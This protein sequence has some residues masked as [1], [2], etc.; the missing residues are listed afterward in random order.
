MP[1][2]SHDGCARGVVAA[3]RRLSAAAA[4]G[5]GPAELAGILAAG[6]GAP[7]TVLAG[8]RVVAATG[9]PLTPAD[10]VAAVVPPG[11][12]QVVVGRPAGPV[13]A[14]LLCLAAE[15]AA[16]AC[17]AARDPA[18]AARRDLLEALLLG[19]AH[20]D[21]ELA[22]WAAHLGHD[23]RPHA[24]AV[25][26]PHRDPAAAEAEIRRHAPTAM[27]TARPD[28][29]V[30]VLGADTPAAAVDRA[31]ALADQLGV[32]AA[33]IGDAYCAAADVARSYGEARWA[34][35]VA[36]RRSGAER[37]LTFRD[38]GVNRLLARFPD[39]AELRSFGEEVIGRLLD[40]EAATG[41]PYLATLTA[42]F[43]VNG[44]P[45]QAAR[46]LHVHPNTI[47]YRMRRIEELTGLRLGEQRD[48]LMA[49]VAVEI[50][51]GMGRA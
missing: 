5:A 38:L 2:P 19:R 50:V 49:E 15:H 25:L 22:R 3:C 32:A 37:V 23:G 9:S 48:R 33:G 1:E 39:L 20:H 21:G 24:V 7:V 51:A 4:R 8:T 26:V 18:G 36:R 40:E 43:Q 10:G 13:P 47:A 31:V 45:S 28:E 41:M 11:A 12:G 35:A 6:V 29:V 34:L 46:R 27:V 17:A 16:L 30:A 42:Y 44:S 14:E